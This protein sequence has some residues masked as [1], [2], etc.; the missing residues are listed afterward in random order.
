MLKP[1]WNQFI[2]QVRAANITHQDKLLK[3]LLSKKQIKASLMY[4]KIFKKT[5]EAFYRISIT[6]HNLIKLKKILDARSAYQSI[7]LF[8][9]RHW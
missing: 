6:P 8:E 3:D 1:M 7:E 2:L 4:K 5:K 9:F